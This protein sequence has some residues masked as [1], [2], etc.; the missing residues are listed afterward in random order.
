MLATSPES[1]PVSFP[2]I[3]P[4]EK[5]QMMDTAIKRHILFYRRH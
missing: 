2:L 1:R 3:K 4:K 5:A